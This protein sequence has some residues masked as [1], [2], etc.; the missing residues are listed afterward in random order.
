LLTGGK[1]LRASVSPP[2]PVL[3]PWK[4]HNASMTVGRNEDRTHSAVIVDEVNTELTLGSALYSLVNNNA[5]PEQVQIQGQLPFDFFGLG[6]Q[7]Q[8]HQQDNQQ[9]QN[10]DQIGNAINGEDAPQDNYGWLQWPEALVAAQQG[11][12]QLQLPGI[13][14]N[15][16]APPPVLLQDLNESPM[17]E[18]P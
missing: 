2:E 18:D 6:Q 15:L 9:Q 11:Q 8:G 3:I 10:Q 13:G 12:Q 5:L 1:I 4:I 7:A 16:N 17:I 14:I